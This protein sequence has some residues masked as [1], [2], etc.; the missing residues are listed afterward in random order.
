MCV[1]Q[2]IEFIQN[3]HFA[4]ATIFKNK[5]SLFQFMRLIEFEDKNGRFY[6]SSTGT[7]S[8]AEQRELEFNEWKKTIENEEEAAAQELNT[9]FNKPSCAITS[10]NRSCV[11]TH[12]L[13]T[14]GLYFNKRLRRST[15]KLSHR[16]ENQHCTH[17]NHITQLAI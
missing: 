6:F 17:S 11:R 14:N 1:Y 10:L 9:Y 2:Q 3:A 8:T 16:K 15:G 4:A 5:S 13:I 12:Y 7:H